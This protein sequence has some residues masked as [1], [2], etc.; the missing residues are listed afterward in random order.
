ME[1]TQGIESKPEIYNGSS[2]Y[3]D[4]QRL[5]NSLTFQNT[6]GIQE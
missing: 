3:L 4:M 1:S 6:M 5:P 2:K